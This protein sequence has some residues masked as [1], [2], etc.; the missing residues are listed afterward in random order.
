VRQ[1]SQLMQLEVAA[2]RDVVL[3]RCGFFLGEPHER[4]L[5]SRVSERM[6]ELATEF[7][8]YLE[9]LEKSPVGGGE[10]QVLVERLC[11]YET[12][13]MRDPADFRALA[14]C[15]LPL[16]TREMRRTGRKRLRVVSAGCSTGQEAY[17][18]AMIMHEAKPELRDIVVEVVGLDISGDALQRARSG[19]YSDREVATLD[20]WRRERYFAARGKEY[21]VVPWLRERVRFLQCNLSKVIPLTQVEV[22]FCRNVLI[23]F[24]PTQRQEVIRSLLASLRLGGFVVVGSADS[25]WEHRDVLQAI[26]VSGTI[27]YRRFKAME[28]NERPRSS[29]GARPSTASC[30]VEPNGRGAIG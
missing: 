11:I 15:I 12:R 10:L 14:C 8:A 2:V 26:R 21:E 29:E 30:G 17:T 1:L 7:P 22:I 9:R 25:T 27:V 4:Y 28:T 24:N 20:P 6:R 5:R 23:Y 16:L 19:R 18:L 3:Q 13:F